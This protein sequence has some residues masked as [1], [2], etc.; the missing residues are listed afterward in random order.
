MEHF[1]CFVVPAIA[2]FLIICARPSAASRAHE[3]QLR[4]GEWREF[5][6]RVNRAQAMTGEID[7][8]R[9]LDS[10]YEIEAANAKELRRSRIYYL[11]QLARKGDLIA[12]QEWKQLAEDDD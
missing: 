10:L 4:D 8:G 12:F 1:I 11:E 2:I 3:R 9:A 7:I 5:E 6:A